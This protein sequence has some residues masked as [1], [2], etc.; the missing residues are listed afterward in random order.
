MSLTGSLPLGPSKSG[1]APEGL[2]GVG[3]GGLTGLPSGVLPLGVL[4]PPSM[5]SPG[6]RRSRIHPAAAIIP[7]MPPIAMAILP[8]AFRRC[9]NVVSFPKTKSMPFWN[10]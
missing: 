7:A 9:S 1:L 5:S 8:R 2:V 6:S 10:V 3:L 4:L